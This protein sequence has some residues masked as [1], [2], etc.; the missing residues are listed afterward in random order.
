[1]L[2]GDAPVLVSGSAAERLHT[3][4]SVSKP[5]SQPLGLLAKSLVAAEVT[6][7]LPAILGPQFLSDQ[8]LDKPVSRDLALY[9]GIQLLR[10]L[11]VYNGSVVEVRALH[12]SVLY[13]QEWKCWAVAEKSAD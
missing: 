9:A 13:S 10:K 7:A 1:M 3:W 11:G 12:Y 5:D 4:T 8:R 6:A 2:A